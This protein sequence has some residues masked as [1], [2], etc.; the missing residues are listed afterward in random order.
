MAT[1][2][3]HNFGCRATQA[4]ASAISFDL[5]GRGY[6]AAESDRAADFVVLN[7]CTVT[8]AADAQARDAVRRIHRENPCACIVVTGCYAQ[9]APE[10]LAALEG[11]SL[12]IGNSHQSALSSII[13]SRAPDLISNDPRADVVP[14]GRLTSSLH[15]ARIFRGEAASIKE[16]LVAAPDAT[17]S[18]TRPTLKIQDGCNHRCSY[19][20]I[21]LVRGRSRSLAP[22]RVVAE[23]HR[24]IKAGAREIV[25]SGIDLGSYGRDLASRTSLQEL[26]RQILNE[27]SLERLRLSS[28]E[29]MDVTQDFIE[30]IAS[31]DRIAPHFHMPLQS[32][33]DRILRAM[34]RWYR[35]AH[36]ARRVELIRERLPYAAI[37]ADVITGFP[38][39]T[40]EE[41]GV[42]M[43]FLEEL[44]LS[45]LHVFS[46]SPRPGTEAAMLGE[47]VSPSEIHRRARELR[48][49]GQRKLAAFRAAQDGTTLRVLTL[50]RQGADST[51]ALSGNYLKLCV[52]GLWPRN[53]WLDVIFN[54]RIS[55]LEAMP[56]EALAFQDDLRERQISAV[57]D[58]KQDV[59]CS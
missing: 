16:I 21:P 19:C 37:G 20:V 2:F 42:T 48:A 12:V 33:S 38:G 22:E 31:S 29:P 45:Y 41:H 51:E 39:E 47:H 13:S 57:R 23:I 5:K 50:G 53:E 1:F 56:A 35:A 30:I 3:I 15:A 52:R 43:Q 36:Y 6:A 55:A 49:L 10:E 8:A 27:T 40:E 59:F 46:F 26:L 17:G 9:R 7:T 58:G 18:R 32:G 34:H 44:P 28:I 4:D 25:L 54:D 11:V 14:L 24:L